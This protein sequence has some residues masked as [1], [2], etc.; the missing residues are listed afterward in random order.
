LNE[1]LG[2]SGETQPLILILTLPH[3]GSKYHF[4]FHGNSFCLEPLPVCRCCFAFNWATN[5][6]P[7]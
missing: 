2:L 7:S 4:L 1:L 3:L 6:W 5:L